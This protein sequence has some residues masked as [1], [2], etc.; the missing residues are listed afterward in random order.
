MPATTSGCLHPRLVDS[1]NPNTSPVRLKVAAIAPSQSI[2]PCCR[3]VLSG[4]RH[5]LT[6]IT[7]IARGT[8]IKN[9][10][11][12]DKC[13]MS[14]PPRTGPMAVV[15][16]VAPDHVP[17]ARPRSLSP[18]DAL[19]RARLPGTRN[20]APTPWIA[21]AAINC[22]T[23]AARPQAT[24]A[25]ANTATPS[26]NILRRPNRSP[27]DPPTRISAAS[28]SPY[29]STTHCTPTTLAPK[30][31]CRAGKATLTTVPSMKAMLDP[32]IVASRIHTFSSGRHG[33]VAMR[34]WIT[35]S[36][37]GGFMRVMDVC[38]Q[39]RGSSGDDPSKKSP[40]RK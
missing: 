26:R 34:E 21:R 10:H 18:N 22:W 8:L 5:R 6:A 32:T 40:G 36:S 27:I 11:R 9:A 31:F 35:A 39:G 37:Q 33:D 38:Y 13:S 3:L 1:M 17:I 23:L 20:A 28:V 15:I 16:A 24:D 14:H 12:H 30:L 19:I 7:A 29:D 25:I 4:T 2:C